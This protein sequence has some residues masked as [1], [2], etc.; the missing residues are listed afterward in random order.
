VIR[1]SDNG[2]KTTTHDRLTD[3]HN[4]GFLYCQYSGARPANKGNAS[5]A[6]VPGEYSALDENVWQS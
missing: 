1:I 6:W 2:V 3:R 5:Q 4:K